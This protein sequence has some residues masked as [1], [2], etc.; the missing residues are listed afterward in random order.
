MWRRIKNSTFAVFLA[1]FAMGVIVPSSVFAAT[2]VQT[3]VCGDFLKPT[4]FSPITDFKTQDASILVSGNAQA[5]L[6]VA[7]TVDGTVNG[8]A[9]AASDG[10]YAVQVSLHV[11]DNTLIASEANG[12]GLMKESDSIVVRRDEI[13]AT[14][15]QVTPTPPVSQDAEKPNLATVIPHALGQSF[16]AVP[17]APGYSVPTIK[18]PTPNEIYTNNR[19]WVVGTAVPGSI[20]TIYLNDTSVAKVTTSPQGGY[21]VTIELRAGGNTLQVKSEK[22]GMSAA[23]KKIE[24]TFVEANPVAPSPSVGTVLTVAAVTTTTVAVGA[25]GA[26]WTVRRIR[27]RF[28]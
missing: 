27:L 3:S 25:G 17:S 10:T 15:L 1:A 12:C 4:I 9:A 21:A 14:E 5:F 8:I 20:V 7:I 22:D 16:V 6:P 2:K 24:V 23:S 11:G 19:V 28:K 13:P 26:T 18:Q